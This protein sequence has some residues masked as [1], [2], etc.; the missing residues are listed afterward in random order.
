M[1]KNL[2]L[3]IICIFGAL[4]RFNKLGALIFH[5]DEPL[6]SVRIA[7]KS[8]SFNV[9]H[10]YGS[11]LYQVVTHFILPL[12]KL[13]FF[14]RLPAVLF[15]ILTI[16]GTY[17]VGKLFFGKK[18]GLSAA[19]FVSF[20]H[21][22]LSYSQYARGYTILTFLSLMSLVFF[23]KAIKDNKTKYWILYIIISVLNAY[24]HL[25]SLMT[26][27]I[28]CAFVGILLIEAL[29]RLNKKKTWFI[30]KKRFI[31]FTFCTLAIIAI[32][33]LLRLPVGEMDGEVTSINWI[34]ETLTRLTAEPTI[35]FFPLVKQIL[36]HHIY[37]SPSPFYFLALFFIFF[38]FIG[39]LIRI[40]KKDLLLLL[41]VTLPFICFYLIKPLPLFY[42]GADRYFI[43]ILPIVFILLAKGMFFLSSSLM[44]IAV[45]VKGIK[46]RE[47]VY[48][49]LTLGFFILLFLLLECFALKG[50]SD[51]RWKLRSLNVSKDVQEFLNDKVEENELIF[52]NT[53]PHMTR[54]LYMTP[55]YFCREKK[56]A[57]MYTGDIRY[58][59]EK[60]EKGLWL[61][62]D[63]SLLGEEQTG[64]FNPDFDEAEIFNVK[65]HSLIHWK[66]GKKALLKEL[67][68]M[69]EFLIPLHPD[70]EAD[71]RLLLAYFHLADMNLEESLKELDIVENQGR[72]KTHSVSRLINL[73]MKDNQNFRD[74]VTN[75]LYSN[76]GRQLWTA[77]YTF[78]SE[79]K[80]DEGITAFDKCIQLSDEFLKPISNEY[81]TLG[82]NFL[83]SRRTEEAI[84]FL[85]KAIELDPQ[86]YFFH[87]ILAEAYWQ[88]DEKNEAI[89]EYRKG[90]NTPSL[91][92]DLIFQ[93]VSQPQLFAVW[94]EENTW[95][96]LWRSDNNSHFSGNI[97]FDKKMGTS[98]K[99]HFSKKDV[100]DRYKDYAAEFEVATNA[101]QIKTL[102]IDMGKKSVLTCYIEINGQLN[103]DRIVFIHSGEHPKQIPFSL[104][105]DEMK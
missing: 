67:I 105:S 68:E 53:F 74:I 30:D 65:G 41:Y 87:L 60:S 22:L 14:S 9:T 19:L 80:L 28:Y 33:F 16:I 8:L 91:S 102:D 99:H 3:I 58:F 17:Y 46:K 2:P 75:S 39:C 35:G 78:L 79:E 66:S 97:Y 57:M 56:K 98:Q 34:T 62:I 23:Y 95:R 29:L 37:Q 48:R 59:N 94:K 26:I 32:T 24:T 64:C 55:L 101:R 27:L 69:L 90:F 88:K 70:K 7:A 83:R 81:F 51:Y 104:S 61:V 45:Y 38:G 13:E 89:L 96:F 82:N 63:Q 72:R 44:S 93:I 84:F 76:I 40:R 6:D 1:K 47:L 103:N 71:Y 31:R 52:F 86:N 5:L 73:I 77:G 18:I 42:M 15:G 20:S 25:I 49:N 43:F 92:D 54:V 85:N 12:G 4:L 50:Y 100:L 36:T 11:V 10:D 21:Y